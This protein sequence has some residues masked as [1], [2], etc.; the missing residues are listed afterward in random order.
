M[1]KRKPTNHIENAVGSCVAGSACTTPRVLREEEFDVEWSQNDS[2]V[3]DRSSAAVDV[4]GE[5]QRASST[6]GTPTMSPPSF[7]PG[8]D[9]VSAMARLVLAHR[10]R[11][12]TR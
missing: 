11:G 10:D 6:H 12:T 1:S 8:P 7:R 4:R 5:E 9:V 3:G 2:A